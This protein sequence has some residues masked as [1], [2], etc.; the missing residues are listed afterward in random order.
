M[1]LSPVPPA[2]P[3]LL[4]G[5]QPVFVLQG[6]QHFEFEPGV[7]EDIDE[8]DQVVEE[9]PQGLLLGTPALRHHRPLGDVPLEQLLP[10]DQRFDD[11]DVVG[12]NRC[13]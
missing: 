7:R 8:V 13:A 6:H 2:H 10:L 12:M 4:F 5:R 3:P 9:I 1:R 11:Q